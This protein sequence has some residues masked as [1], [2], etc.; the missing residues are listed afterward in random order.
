MTSTTAARALQS[1][2]QCDLR[3]DELTRQLYATDASIYQVTPYGVALPR[4]LEEASQVMAAA[5][6][7]NL[8]VI[9][10]GGGTG[11][12]GGAIGEG[13]VVDLSRWNRGITDLNVD[14]RTV[15]VGTGVVLD[16]L[17]AW[18]RP[19]GLMFGPDVATSSR[20]TLGGMIANN[21]SGARVPLYGT[22]TDHV[23]ALEVIYAGGVVEEISANPGAPD[24]FWPSVDEAVRAMA[25]RIR[26]E[27]HE[28]IIKRWPGY[29][30]DRYLRTDGHRTRLFGG[31]EG[32]LGLIFSAELSLVPIPAEK[33]MGLIFFDS[34]TEAMAA[35]VDLFD[36]EPAAIEHIDDVLF[37]QTRGQL[38]FKEARDLL[39]L[40]DKPCK[41]ILLVEFY[42]DVEDKLAALE[43]KPLGT[44]KRMIREAGEMAQ[45]MNMRKSGLSLLTGRKGDAKPTAGIEDVAVPPEKLPEYVAGLEALMKPLGLEGSF[46]GHAASGLLHVR[47]VVDMHDAEDVRKFRQLA[48]GVSAL[49]KQFKG[50]LCAEHGVGIARSEFMKEQVSQDLLGCMQQIKDLIDPK[51]LM[52]PGKVLPESPYRIDTNL[53]QGPGS[54]IHDNDLPFESTLAFSSKDES[55]MGN[56]EQCNGCGGCRKGE[57]TMCPTFLVTGEDIMAT[58]GR[59]NTI[60]AVLEKRVDS[61][62]DPLL[63]PAL[64]A[65]LSNCL[66]CKACKTECPS[67]VDLAQ[68][69]AD[70][71]YAKLRRHGVPL[72]TRMVSRVD[73]LGELASR[74]PGIANYFMAQGWVKNLMAR[75]AGFAPERPFP[76]YADQRF[77]TWFKKR[78]G[79]GADAKRGTVL[80]WDDCFTRFNEPNIGQAAVKVLEAA[81]FHVALVEQRAC[82]GRPAFSTGRL[83]IAAEMGRHNLDLLREGDAPI[84]FLEPSC[85]SM[86]A[87]DYKELRLDDA[88]TVGRRAVLFEHF[89]GELLAREPEALAFTKE[90]RKTAIHAHCHA[91][92]LTKAPAMAQ[93]ASRIPDNDVTLLNTGC[94]G[95]AG[96]FGQMAEK[97]ELSKHVAQPLVDQLAALPADTHLV[98]SGTSC[99]H[100]ITHF[101]DRHPLHMAELLA[102]AL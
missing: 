49:T 58:R 22:T 59:A 50:S 62:C 35:T 65:A 2:T 66:S 53:R 30:L 73:V 69:K 101:T 54:K 67:N 44:R 96:A 5:A 25:P 86:F 1:A 17:N 55:F 11:L 76:P 98:A 15:R 74:T 34:L 89:I 29:G 61:D 77:D 4:T 36:L 64:D 82:C 79:A 93:L 43:A 52:N 100:Q 19:H 83:D 3:F 85:F 72:G 10:R 97:Y 48:E 84:L 27:F 26:E 63:S 33:A 80:L 32:T 7:E 102:N 24:G 57:P 37:D 23:N 46:Y 12:A 75:A 8:P 95:M 18:L 21:S 9:P 41:S 45:V 31:S 99:R 81:G 87:Q 20:A 91:K 70:L 78:N 14:T 42:H 56:L 16:Q 51:N 71:L 68:L 13:L 88:E 39:E 28:K 38:A 60:R 40:D 6:Q 47:P 94:C 90:S 92:A